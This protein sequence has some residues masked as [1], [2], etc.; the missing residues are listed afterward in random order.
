ML[1]NTIK[2]FIKESDFGIEDVLDLDYLE[3]MEDE[4][5]ELISN[6]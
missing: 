5:E 4:E 6:E 3:F 1:D 2:Q